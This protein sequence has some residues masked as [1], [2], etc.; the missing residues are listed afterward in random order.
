MAEAMGAFGSIINSPEQ[1]NELDI[2][3]I[4]N[5]SGPTLLDIRTDPD[6]VP[7]ISMRT[8]ILAGNQ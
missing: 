5:R 7:P 1:L 6:E 4:C 8:N 3:A 2:N